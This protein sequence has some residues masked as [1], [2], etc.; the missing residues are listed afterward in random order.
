VLE[1]GGVVR[2]WTVACYA[3]GS[4]FADGDAGAVAFTEVPRF[5]EPAGTGDEGSLR[6]PLP[7]TVVALRVAAGD[8]VEAGQELLVLEAMKMQHAVRADRAGQIE[9]LPVRAGDTVDVG[10]TLVVIR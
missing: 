10:A 3:D 8:K 2:R 6:A 4:V 1:A 5:P 7:G 9:S